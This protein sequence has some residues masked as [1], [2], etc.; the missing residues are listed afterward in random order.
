MSNGTSSSIVS[1]IAIART[2]S[3]LVDARF[4]G[5]GSGVVIH[6]ALRA[7]QGGW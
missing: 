3:I 6:C 1:W 7:I 2:F 5:V 4:D